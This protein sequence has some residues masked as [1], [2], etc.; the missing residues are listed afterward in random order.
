MRFVVFVQI[1]GNFILG[2]SFIIVRICDLF[3]IADTLVAK[4]KNT[5][6]A[7]MEITALSGSKD[8]R[9]IMI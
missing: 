5:I 1:P 2:L 9:F 3:L 7:M 4:T 8:R 6:N